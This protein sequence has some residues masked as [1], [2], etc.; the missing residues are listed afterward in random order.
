VCALFLLHHHHLCLFLFLFLFLFLLRC[1]ARGC[2]ALQKRNPKLI[3]QKDRKSSSAEIRLLLSVESALR[4]LFII[5]FIYRIDLPDAVRLF[6]LSFFLS[7]YLIHI[8]LSNSLSTSWTINDD[9]NTRL[10]YILPA[11]INAHHHHHHHR[12]KS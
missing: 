9:E 2:R 3:S 6:S 8:T 4:I 7:S 1:K 10:H 11:K 12:M 5:L